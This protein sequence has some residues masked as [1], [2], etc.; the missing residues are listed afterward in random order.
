M[1]LASNAARSAHFKEVDPVTVEVIRRRLVAIADQI[2]VNVSRTA[3]SPYIYEYKDYAVAIVDASGDLICQCSGGIPI[4]V[5]DVISATVKDGIEIYGSAGFSL[6]DIVVSNYSGT[7]GQ[8]LNNVVM[9]TPVFSPGGDHVIAF[10]VVVM[11]WVD[12]GGKQLG[13]ISLDAT[14]IFQEGIQLRTVKMHKGGEKMDDVYRIIR[15]NTRLPDSVMGDI[16]SQVGGCLMGRVEIEALIAKYGLD[17]FQAAIELIWRQSETAARRAIKEIPDGEYRATTFLDS[18]GLTSDEP[19]QLTVKVIISGDKF[20]VDLSGVAPQ[21]KSPINSGRSGGGQ[22]V[23]RLAFRYLIIPEGD[24]NEG[25]FR[26]LEL[27]LPPGTLVSADALAPMGSYNVPLPSLIDL[28][29]KALSDVMPDRT[30]AGHF[31][32]FSTLAITGRR[33]DGGELFQ[34]HDSGFGGWGA[35]CDQDGPGPFRTMCHGDTR[36]VP[37]EVQEAT[38]P[39]LIEEFSLRQDSGGAGAFRGGLGLQRAYKMLAPCEILTRFDRTKFPPWGLMGGH[40]GAS[41]D[42]EVVAQDGSI[43]GGLRENLKL[44]AGD[45]L[46]VKTGGGGGYGDPKSRSR[47]SIKADLQHGYISE[48]AAQTIYGRERS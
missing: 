20:T 11:H 32:N 38:Y 3:F 16:D 5:A 29:I 6:G 9:Y 21:A 18:D 34:C 36:L 22:T 15:H 25:S 24:V 7:V 4:F 47:E 14:D 27:V 2:D 26:P 17:T 33:E 35:L 48:E 30:A 23:A 8:H 12:V 45:R 44:S 43:R 13:S 42:V 10:M 46:V 41:G 40:A 37:I 1:T 39:L 31:G 28:V 19:V